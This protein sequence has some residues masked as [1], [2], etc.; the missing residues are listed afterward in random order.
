MGPRPFGRQAA[1]GRHLPR[2]NG[3]LQPVR[4]AGHLQHRRGRPAHALSTTYQGAELDQIIATFRRSR[5]DAT[6]A[7]LYFAITTSP[8]WRDAIKIAEAKAA[9]HAAPVF[10]YQLA[11]PTRPSCPAP[12]SR[13]ARRTPPT[14][15]SSSPTPPATSRPGRRRAAATA[16]HM[17]AT[18]GRL[19]PHSHPGRGGR[20]DMARL[21]PEGPCHDVDRRRLQDRQRPDRER[22]ALLEQP[23]LNLIAC[24]AASRCPTRW[25]PLYT[26]QNDRQ[27]PAM[28]QDRPGHRALGVQGHHHT[29][30]SR[31]RTRCVGLRCLA[32]RHRP[33]VHAGRK[34]IL[35]GRDRRPGIR[36]TTWP[37]GGGR[38]QRW[39]PPR[40]RRLS[41]RRES[42]RFTGRLRHE[43]AQPRR[44]NDRSC[45]RGG[46]A[47][48]GGQRGCRSR[49]HGWRCSGSRDV[50]GWGCRPSCGRTGRR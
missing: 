48:V 10:M 38:D 42:R 1:D 28:E 37:R 21:H 3:V 18:V 44:R 50:R 11:Y 9:Q 30:G 46:R 4:P 49:G 33:G 6:P 15:P 29:A 43:P 19:R 36:T 35:R 31:D 20:A 13:S 7:Q 40:R 25:G 16:Q 41:H 47:R 45:P 5:P 8:I 39:S 27:D 32:D 34:R 22:A 24:G 2:R 23:G 14:S 26:P 17:S 12:T